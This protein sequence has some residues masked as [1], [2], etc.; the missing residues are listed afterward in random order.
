MQ[1][2]LGAPD[3][4]STIL[5]KCTDPTGQDQ[6]ARR[7]LGAFPGNQVLFTRDLPTLYASG[8]S[9]L[10]RF[11]DVMTGVALAIA[12]LMMALTMYTVVLERTRE[13]GILKALGAQRGWIARLVVAESLA[14]SSLGLGAGVGLAV[15]GRVGIVALTTLDHIE[16]APSWLAVVAAVC[17]ASGLIGAL[18]PAWRAAGLDAVRALSAE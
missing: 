1:D 14:V 15:V 3:R 2:L 16:F 9:S 13:V 12:T 10:N 4:C 18:Y 6:V 7:L 17:F 11:L 8:F 5:V